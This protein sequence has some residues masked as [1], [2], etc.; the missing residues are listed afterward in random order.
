MLM[1]IA[2][3]RT[4]SSS[5]CWQ[6]QPEL[7]RGGFPS[8][9][10]GEFLH[11]GSRERPFDATSDFRDVC[12]TAWFKQ[13]A[14]KSVHKCLSL[15]REL[16]LARER[17]RVP[18]VIVGKLFDYDLGLTAFQFRQHTIDHWA[19]HGNFGM[20]DRLADAPMVPLVLLLNRRDALMHH[21][22]MKWSGIH[23]FW[24]ASSKENRT[25]LAPM[26]L[27]RVDAEQIAL[28]FDHND[29][30]AEAIQ[31]RAALTKS[32]LLV[33]DS[34]DVFFRMPQVAAAV[35]KVLRNATTDL[36]LT[37]DLPAGEKDPYDFQADREGRRKL[38]HERVG[39]VD[40]VLQWLAESKWARAHR[41][42]YYDE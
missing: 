25:G 24:S 10:I 22:S 12:W 5:L 2:R 38:L 35:L 20:L 29:R 17:K 27:T 41:Q 11:Q 9:C 31:A 32:R 6:L 21:V 37:V 42:F 14:T 36:L 13:Q 28:D 18:S 23:D 26:T 34:V 30:K 40:E 33:L 8:L 16:V 19:Q 3:P 1:I 7:R 39:N 4:G 15:T